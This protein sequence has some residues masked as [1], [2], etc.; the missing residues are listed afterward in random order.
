MPANSVGITQT[1]LDAG[2]DVGAECGAGPDQPDTG[3]GNTLGLVASGA[4]AAEQ[5]LSEGLIDTLIG[6][7][8]DLNTGNGGCLMTALYHTVECQ[9]QREVAEML[10][11]RGAKVDLC[12]AAGLGKLDLVK[13]FFNADGSLKPDAYRL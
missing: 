13:G 11:D 12:Y 10:F 6:A 3:G 1:R 4:R 7:G 9:K 2:A 5:G 8:S